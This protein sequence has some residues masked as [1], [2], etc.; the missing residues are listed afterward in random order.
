MAPQTAIIL[1]AGWLIV[2]IALAT[3][4]RERSMRW[5]ITAILAIL[6]AFSVDAAFLCIYYLAAK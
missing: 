1:F 2:A 3:L 5:K 4:P 6:L